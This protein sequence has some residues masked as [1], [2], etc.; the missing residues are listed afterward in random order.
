MGR[1][2][3]GDECDVVLLCVPDAEI[4]RAAAAVRLEVLVGHTSGATT[5]EAIGRREAFSMHPLISVTLDGAN[6]VGAGCAVAGSSERALEVATDLARSLGMDPFTVAESDRALYHAAASMASNY[7]VTLEDAAERLAAKAGVERAH[8]VPLVRS[9]VEQWA[10]AG[11]T[12]ALTG[13]VARGDDETVSR[14]RA[15]VG[16]RAPQLLPMWDALTA[17]TRDLA[18]SRAH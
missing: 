5:L 16:T 2:A 6:F 1:G 11:A 7:L 9:A 18:R 15:A 13:P 17:A 3:C 8:L 4:A 14:Q 10:R 12:S